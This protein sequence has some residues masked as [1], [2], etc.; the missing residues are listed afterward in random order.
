[1]A[2]QKAMGYFNTDAKPVIMCEV[3]KT[4]ADRSQELL[5][6]SADVM[7]RAWETANGAGVR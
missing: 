7:S 2:K 3:L 1:M 5:R 6:Y 4:V